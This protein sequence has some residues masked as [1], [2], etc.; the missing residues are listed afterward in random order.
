MHFPRFHGPHASRRATASRWLLTA[1]VAG[2]PALLAAP[3]SAQAGPAPQGTAR[4]VSAPSTAGK[5]AGKASGKGASKAAGKRARAPRLSAR[6]RIAADIGVAEQQI[7][8]AMVVQDTSTLAELWGDEYTFTSLSGETYSKA[9]RLESVMSPAFMVDEAAEV[10]PSELDIV[11]VYGN[12][13]VVQS[14]L[15]PPGT[16][17]SGSRGGRA[18]LLSVWVRGSDGKWRTVAAQATAV[19]MP[20]PAPA[21]KKR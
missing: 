16:A 8:R 19:D 13:A 14:R 1:L 20:L 7:R 11:R 15:A 12:V 5:G 9:E 10:L 18:K 2:S 4:P 3:L 21:K 17:Q 6:E